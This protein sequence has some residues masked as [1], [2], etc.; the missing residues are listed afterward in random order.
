ML[1]RNLVGFYGMEMMVL[2]LRLKYLGLIF[3]FLK[4]KEDWG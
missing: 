1:T 4:R 2:R 3:I